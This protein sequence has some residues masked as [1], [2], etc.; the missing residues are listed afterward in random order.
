MKNSIKSFYQEQNINLNPDNFTIHFKFQGITD[1][2]YFDIL[3]KKLNYCYNTF[4][5][6]EAENKIKFGFFIQG[7]IIHESYYQYDDRENNCFLLIFKVEKCIN[8]IVIKQN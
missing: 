5:L 8:V 2:D 1:G 6:I 7:A 3:Y 4:I